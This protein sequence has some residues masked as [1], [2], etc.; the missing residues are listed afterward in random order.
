[1]TKYVRFPCGFKMC[2][3]VSICQYIHEHT[4][5]LRSSIFIFPP[6][7]ADNPG[8]LLAL[9]GISFYANFFTK[10]AIKS[11]TSN[12]LKSFCYKRKV[13]IEWF[14][15][16]V[17]IGTISLKEYQCLDGYQYILGQLITK[18]IHAWR[19]L[20]VGHCCRYKLTAVYAPL[21]FQRRSKLFKAKLKD[22]FPCQFFKSSKN[23]PLPLKFWQ[24]YL[25]D[26]EGQRGEIADEL[27]RKRSI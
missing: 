22:K 26:W 11:I 21:T 20:S 4:K 9:T 23:F 17:F 10:L 12:P 2:N 27:Q 7:K 5:C 18:I 19:W 13:Q 1:M 3:L 24:N 25:I 15:I 16:P 6:G 8:C 14:F